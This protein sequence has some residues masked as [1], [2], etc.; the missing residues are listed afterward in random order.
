VSAVC[1]F[2][3]WFLGMCSLSWFGTGAVVG[4]VGSSICELSVSKV[5]F[6]SVA[7]VVG[8]GVDGAVIVGGETAVDGNGVTRAGSMMLQVLLCTG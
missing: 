7:T 5:L 2:D 1:F 4:D 6:E 3:M 8:G